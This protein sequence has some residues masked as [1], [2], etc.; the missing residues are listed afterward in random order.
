MQQHIASRP[1]LHTP[2]TSGRRSACFLPVRSLC[3]GLLL[4]FG[5]LLSGRAEAQTVEGD[6]AALVALY[7]ATGGAQWTRGSNWKTS[8][9]IG[10]WYGVTT[11]TDGRVTDV[12]LFENNLVGSLP[13]ALGNLTEL[14]VLTLAFNSMLTGS[15]PTELGN[16]IALEQLAL[17]G[18][19]LTGSIPSALGTLSKLQGLDVSGNDLTGSI[20]SELGNLTELK[21][22]YFGDNS[23]LTGSI[24]VELGNL[25]KLEKFGANGC[26]LNGSIPVA[27]GNLS[28]LKY[29]WLHKN[30]LSGSIP[31]ELGN[32]TNLIQLHLN[33]N[34]LSGTIPAELGDLTSLT[35]LELQNNELSGEIPAELG[36]LT[37]LVYLFLHSNQLSG[38]IPV[39]LGN[40][41]KLIQVQLQDNTDLTGVIPFDARQTVLGV[42]VIS[43]TDLCAPPTLHVFWDA[44]LN[45]DGQACTTPMADRTFLESLYDSLG[46]DDWGDRTNWKSTEPLAD[47]YGVE[48]NEAG[49]VTGLSLPDN[50]LAGVIPDGLGALTGLNMLDLS[51]ND[52]TGVIPDAL[53]TL[54]RLRRVDLSGN[55]LTGETP[56]WLGDL[57]VLE[58][59]DLSDTQLSGSIPSSFTQTSALRTLDVSGTTVCMPPDLDFQNWLDDSGVVYRGDRCERTDRTALVAL[60]YATDGPS[61]KR[62]N[63]LSDAPLGD[64]GGVGANVDNRV[65]YVQISDFGLKGTIPR[66]LG[67]LEFLER[68][69]L[70]TNELTGPLP[71]ELGKLTRLEL[72]WVGQTGLTGPIPTELQQL[73]LTSLR[74]DETDLCVPRSESFRTWLETVLIHPLTLKTC[75]S[76]DGGGGGGGGGSGGGGG[77][78]GGGGRTRDRHGNTPARATQVQ[79]GE[80]APWTASTTGQIN[81]SRDIDYFRLTVPYAG[82]LVVETTGSTDTVGTVWQDDEELDTAD[83]GG[84]RRNF[85][86]SVRVEAGPVVV[87]V[88]GNGTRTGAYTLETTLLVGYLENPGAG[89][90]QSGIGVLSGWVCDAEGI[91]IE[92]GNFTPQVAAYGTGRLDTA[93]VCGDTDNGFGLL[94]N[95]NLLED[96]EHEVVALVDGVELGRA[97]VTVTTL[98]QEFL[99]G[100]TGTCEVADFPTV[101]ETVTLEWQQTSQ[102]FVIAGESAP[103]GD[104]AVRSGELEGY[105]ENPGSNSFQSGIGVISGWV[106]A[107][108]EVLIEI[109]GSPQPAGYGTERLDT[110]ESCGDTDNGF[111]LLFNWNLLDDG[112]HT[113]VAYADEVELGRA[114]VQ[115]TTL[116]QEFLR[117]AEGECVVEDF[118]TVGETVTL[119]WQQN[120]QNF[121]ITQVE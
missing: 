114:T 22:L 102:N 34:S 85:R 16:L 13:G 19:N 107:A 4:L 87:A 113:V 60:Y 71:S 110:V 93:D 121:V 41:T 84:T 75:P 1:D 73:P 14:K 17:F 53:E 2:C 49:S 40:L 97:T 35:R 28:Q 6:R 8:E 111:G 79:L 98:G 94:F 3:V 15:I 44:N 80:S 29:L 88:E 38:E 27:L 50:E 9:S 96:G 39:E 109:N 58:H 77:G 117:G 64:W 63:W 103:S 12:D 106:C 23:M 33:D 74:I 54:I 76:D 26:A 36:R 57:E 51:G 116:G 18:N 91:E 11:D 119:E 37:E 67:D 43:N 20:P 100:V 89:S 56:S 32:L 31:A 99:R 45:Y 108:D 25:S 47:W 59:L 5:V 78:G 70:E 7:D 69:A 92:I 42:L 95:W 90:F 118:P 52:L 83:S 48:T 115:V 72:L 105:L 81:T 65:T 61:W 101:G 112:E 104:N 120:S 66:E 62:A 10:D 82:V 68:L 86:L 55:T 24:P 30:S 46:G 21:E